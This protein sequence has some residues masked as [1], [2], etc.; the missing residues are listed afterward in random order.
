MLECPRP[1]VLMAEIRQ[2]TSA[3]LLAG[4]D[5]Q[6][7]NQAR[8]KWSSIKAGG[9]ARAIYPARLI[10][11][12]I[13]DTPGF[14][15]ETVASGPSV[16]C[17]VL[18]VCA[19]NETAVQAVL[20]QAPYLRSLEHV[21]SGEARD[22]GQRLAAM[23][24]GFVLGGESTVTVRG[25]GRGGRNQELVLGALASFRRGLFL[26]FGTD[27]VDGNSKGAG[28]FIDRGIIE[29]GLDPSP[30]LQTN[31]SESYFQTVGSQIML[32]PTGTNVADLVLSLP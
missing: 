7:L 4:A 5:I 13:H 11:L 14:P 21:F 32:G 18:D 10:T 22:V 20:Q 31:D 1:G 19:D 2:R 3:L 17:D 9:L 29:R 28:A 25:D 15:V 16:P 27:G 8:S 6:V 12:V 24:P 23:D 30:Y 26:A